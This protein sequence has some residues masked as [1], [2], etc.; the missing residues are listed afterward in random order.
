MAK[1]VRFFVLPCNAYG[2]A[3]LSFWVLRRPNFRRPWSL[4]RWYSTPGKLGQW[5]GPLMEVGESRGFTA[6]MTDRAEKIGASKEQVRKEREAE[7]RE[8][9]YAG[10]GDEDD[11]MAYDPS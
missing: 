9:K 5:S 1:N 7:G 10:R 8:N 11:D 4:V 3:H 6:G 2:S